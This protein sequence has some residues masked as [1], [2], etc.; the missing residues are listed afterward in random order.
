MRAAVYAGTRNVYQ[1]MIPSMKSL[2][3]HSNVEKIYFLIEDNEFPYELPPEVECINVS[4]Q[5]WFNENSPQMKNRCSYMVLLRAVFTKLFPHL[6]RILTIDNDTIV[7]EN[8]SELWD[9]DMNNYYIAGCTEFQKTTPNFTY[10]NMGVAMINLKAWRENHIDDQ[11][12]KDLNTYYF[13]EAEQTAINRLCQGHILVLDSMYNRNNYTNL[14]IGK[15][16][17]I[18]Y[19]AIKGWQQF[20][21]IQKYR[22][23]EIIRNKPDDFSLDII[24]PHYNNVNGLRDTL[25]SIEISVAQVTVVDDCS[26]KR[27]G[28]EQL[29]ADFP[30][31]NFLQL[32]QNSGPGIARQYGINHTSRPYFMFIDAGDCIAS[33][34]VLTRAIKEIETH[35]QA[36]IMCYTWWN[37]DGRSYFKKDIILLPAKIFNREFIELYHLRFSDLRECSYSNEDR[38]FMAPCKLILKNIASYDKNMRVCYNNNVLYKRILDEN[39]ITQANNNSFYWYKHIPGLAHNAEHVVK[40]CRENGLHWNIQMQLITYYLVY[41]Y[42]CYLRCAKNH[43]DN[44]QDNLKEIKYFYTHVYKQFEMVNHKV[45]EH[46]YQ[47]AVPFLLKLTSDIVPRI[48][49]N[50][51]I[52]E[53]KND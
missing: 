53:I 29:K 11:L 33:K 37:E 9:L 7:R 25:N 40:I 1:D 47:K 52:G 3:I 2:L 4:D 13:E 34:K 21:L 32:E 20:P 23:I 44:L 26:T 30:T 45:L 24:I 8:I 42:E 16:K 22:D 27:E 10:I 35:S 46:Y 48:N 50:R 12:V 49:I 15:E 5:Q 17:I 14:R 36:Y 18:H 28:F 19:A 6:D 43:P 41:L 39:S 51:F 31:V 38:G